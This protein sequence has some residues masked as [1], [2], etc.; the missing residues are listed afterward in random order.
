MFVTT[1]ESAQGQGPQEPDPVQ[2]ANAPEE[3]QA[4][5]EVRIFCV[6]E[7]LFYANFLLLQVL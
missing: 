5:G 4:K 3:R 6:L 1:E 2:H 7:L